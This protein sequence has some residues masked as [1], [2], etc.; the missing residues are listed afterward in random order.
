[1]DQLERNVAIS[2]APMTCS[3]CLLSQIKKK[4]TLSRLR[5]FFSALLFSHMEKNQILEIWNIDL[6]IVFT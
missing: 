3:C 4:K 1:M 5:I 6:K 2:Q